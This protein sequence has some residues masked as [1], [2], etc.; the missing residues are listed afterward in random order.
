MDRF[1]KL[2]EKFTEWKWYKDL[3]TKSVFLHLLLTANWSDAYS[4]DLLIKRG[5]RLTSESELSE[6]LGLSRQQIRTALKHLELTNEITKISTKGLTNQLTNLKTLIT[7]E[8][9]NDY[10]GKV[11][12]SNQP[13]NQ[14]KNQTLTNH[15][16]D[17]NQP[18]YLYYKNN[19][20][21]NNYNLKGI[22]EEEPVDNFDHWSKEPRQLSELGKM[23]VEERIER[24][25]IRSAQV[26]AEIERGEW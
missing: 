20:N 7:V 17:G 3:A 18:S 21:Y 19:N 24:N 2:F 6:E 14:P 23:S 26:L 9:Y 16:P 15:Q 11:I 13:S 25:R 12:H 1:V 8:K 5:Q 10:Q 22:E 4:G